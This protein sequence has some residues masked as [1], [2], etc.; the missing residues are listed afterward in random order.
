[1]IGVK[2]TIVTACVLLAACGPE[3]QGPAA[4]AA[5]GEVRHPG[6]VDSI[7]PIEEEMKRFRAILGPEP[8]G[9]AGGAP[10]LEA[11]VARFTTALVHA[12]TAALLDMQLSRN[13]FGWLYYP[14]T[15]FTARPYE[16]APATVW[17]QIESG[18]SQGLGRLLDRLAGRPLTVEGHSCPLE[19]RNEGLNRVWEGCTVRIPFEA[20]LFGSIVERDGVFKFVSYTN[21]F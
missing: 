20:T 21:G 10:S 13:E 12:D 15:R 2:A 3:S 11:L 16:L 1:V 9:L 7:F 6:V 17:F 14:T 8:T 4:A 18:S 19:P 5:V